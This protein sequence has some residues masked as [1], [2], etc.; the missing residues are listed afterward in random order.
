M[1]MKVKLGTAR[2]S[3]VVYLNIFLL[4]RNLLKGIGK[5]VDYLSLDRLFPGQFPTG[6]IPNVSLS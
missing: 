6:Y 1:H 4:F 2:N 5:S 3:Q